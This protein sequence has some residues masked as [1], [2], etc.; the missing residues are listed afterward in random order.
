MSDLRL[1]SKEE[2]VSLY[3]QVLQ[4]EKDKIVKAIRPGTFVPFIK[5]GIMTE[6]QEEDWSSMSREM[7]RKALIDLVLARNNLD[8]YLKF[9]QGVYYVDA[10]KAKRIFKFIADLNAV[11]L[12]DPLKRTGEM[13]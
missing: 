3:S 11:G 6:D 9:S 5:T 7:S 12:H 10:V 13:H 8:C 4:N 1:Y 2:L